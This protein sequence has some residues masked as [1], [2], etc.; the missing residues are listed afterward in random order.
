MGLGH[1][2]YGSAINATH[3]N[4]LIT[5]TINPVLTKPVAFL[6]LFALK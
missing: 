3:L 2:C 6:F 1:R 4:T 5:F